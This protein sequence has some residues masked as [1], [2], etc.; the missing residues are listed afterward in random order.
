MSNNI[1]LRF[2]PSP[3]GPLHIGGLRTALYNFLI[4]KSL[5]GKFIIRIEDTDR[6]RFDQ[7]AEKH[8]LDSLEWCGIIPDEGPLNGGNYGP[9]RQSE[10]KEIYQKKIKKLIENGDAYYA[11]DKTDELDKQRKLSEKRG[12]TF[13]YNWENR[14]KF[15][16]SFTLSEEETKNLIRSGDYVIRYKTYNEGEQNDIVV[17]DEIRGEIKINLKLLDDKIIFKKDGMPTY[18]FANVVDDYEMKI[19]HVVRGEEWLPS[20]ALHFL[21]YKSF[22]W[23]PPKFAHLPLI[24]KPTGKGK[25]SKRDG[26][27]YGIPVYPITW[28]GSSKKF[29]GF[30]EVGFENSSLINFI[31]LIGWNPGDEKEI[32]SLDELIKSFDIKRIIKGGAKYDYDKAIW[33]NQE[34]LKKITSDDIFKHIEKGID[35]NELVNENKIDTLISLA[36]ERVSFKKEIFDECLNIISYSED[37]ILENM[38]KINFTD[39]ILKIIKDFIK[40]LKE[41]KNSNSVKLKENYF[42]K[43]KENNIK[44]GDGMKSLRVMITGKIS[45]PDLFTIL[46]IIKREILI[47][48]LEKSIKII[49]D[50]NRN[51]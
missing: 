33:F 13:I 27:K 1:R 2:A 46:E 25:L 26:E 4:S 11:F 24:L 40:N 19:S 39:H 38:K 45:G 29:E 36:K 50:Q 44:I 32:F 28:E 41:F 20:L 49:N 9:Y 3:T 8:I 37:D 30:R 14:S 43:L 10:R 12:E 5:G 51:Y 42:N 6:K 23:N 16:N 15:K 35:N 21:L 22:N 31:S 18:H 17:S 48:R 34:H 47:I 7:R